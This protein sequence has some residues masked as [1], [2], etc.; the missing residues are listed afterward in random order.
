MS[1]FLEIHVSE[2][3]E[4]LLPCL[5]DTLHNEE[6]KLKIGLDHLT[7]KSSENGAEMMSIGQNMSFIKF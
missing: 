3:N 5:R 2:D 1:H 7:F 4:I 6:V